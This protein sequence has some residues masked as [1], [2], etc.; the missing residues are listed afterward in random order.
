LTPRTAG[1]NIIANGDAE[2]S[3]HFIERWVP[4]ARSDMIAAIPV[5]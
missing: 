4:A 3:V 1:T 5:R 2:N